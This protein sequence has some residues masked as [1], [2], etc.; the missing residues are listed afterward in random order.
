MITQR[1]SVTCAYHY[2]LRARVKPFF[3]VMFVCT[4]SNAPSKKIYFRSFSVLIPSLSRTRRHMFTQHK[5]TKL[6]SED[7]CMLT[8]FFLFHGFHSSFLGIVLIRS[9][10]FKLTYLTNEKKSR[11]ACIQEMK[12]I[13]LFKHRSKCS[14]SLVLPSPIRYFYFFLLLMYCDVL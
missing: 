2:N 10:Y 12:M 6:L 4:A 1:L 13:F 14:T 8:I 9:G 11:E 7:D 5:R 3:E